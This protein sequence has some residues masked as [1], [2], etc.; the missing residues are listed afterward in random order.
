MP[1]DKAGIEA[2]CE[3]LPPP[4]AFLGGQCSGCS[5]EHTVPVSFPAGCCLA[6]PGGVGGDARSPKGA[7]RPCGGSEAEHR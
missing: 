3:A 6:A 7:E 1:P 2:G 4:S 5:A